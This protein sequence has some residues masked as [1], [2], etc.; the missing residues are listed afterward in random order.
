MGEL[1]FIKRIRED[2][3][4]H[5][6]VR[7]GP[8][9]DCAVLTGHPRDQIVTTDTLMEGQHFNLDTCDPV[10]VGRKSMAVSIS[11]IA[12]MG[13]I[14]EVVFISIC[15]PR[16]RS[17]LADKIYQ[18][19]RSL[20]ESYQISI[21]GGDTNSW[22]GP[23]VITTTI[24]G[25]PHNRGPVMRSGAKVNSFIIVTGP[26]GGSIHGHHLKF[27]PL[28]WLAQEIMHL[29]PV[30]A[31]IDLSDGLASDLR[32]ICQESGCSA[33]LDKESIP[34]RS[35]TEHLETP[36]RIEGAL[37]DGEDFEL[38]L[39]VSSQ[40]WEILQTSAIARQLHCIGKIVPLRTPQL[41]W[42]DGNAIQTK[43]YEHKL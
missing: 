31:M 27:E 43:G 13:G 34:L 18:G 22:D 3:P 38:C 1:E 9:D 42:S 16:S 10:D 2:I 29:V 41:S 20:A 36:K 40:S 39:V 12:A 28:V 26:L 7:K 21:A 15:L 4:S 14:P 17:L 30:E 5:P 33:V 37:S 11:D 8:G 19:I 6:M 32:H 25:R 35:V 24:M 23:L